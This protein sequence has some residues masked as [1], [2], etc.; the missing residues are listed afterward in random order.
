MHELPL[1][2]RFFKS[3]R[4]NFFDAC[5][6]QL[7]LTGHYAALFYFTSPVFFGMMGTIFSL[8]FLLATLANAGLD[9]TLSAFFIRIVCSRD[10]MKQIIM[11]HLGFTLFLAF[12]LGTITLI[13]SW[14]ISHHLP[15]LSCTLALILLGILMCES[16]KK[17]LRMFLQLAFRAPIVAAIESATVICY[18]SWVW[19]GYYYGQ[20][21]TLMHLFLPMFACWLCATLAYSFFVIQLYKQ[22]PQKTVAPTELIAQTLFIK[23]RFFNMLNQLVHQLF[24]SNF[25][26][27]FFAMRGGFAVAGQL[28]LICYISYGITSALQKIIGFSASA[29][30]SNLIGQEV[31]VMR[32]AFMLV[33]KTLLLFLANIF[34]FSFA[35]GLGF[36]FF[37]NASLTSFS[38]QVPLLILIFSMQL[39]ENFFTAFER[40]LIVQEQAD[41]LT[42]ING[43]TALTLYLTICTTEQLSLITTLSILLAI[44]FCAFLI[45]RSYTRDQNNPQKIQSTP[46][47]K[48]L[49]PPLIGGALFLAVHFFL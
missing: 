44:R 21:L 13:S 2:S 30:F 6:Y 46:I 24:S 38:P 3:I 35:I 36:L 19:L 48:I 11:R 1:N 18:V 34:L 25:L 5:V 41:I 20:S 33:Q 12:T 49:Y 22:L 43:G 27:P 47:K 39:S 45:L 17:S 40:L 15:P 10:Q 16:I 8:V 26:V 32:H 28:K 29:F 7:I 9:G 14:F 42:L 23:S 4:W 37:T 31:K